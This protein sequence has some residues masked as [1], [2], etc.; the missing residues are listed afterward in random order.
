MATVVR[1]L[2]GQASGAPSE[3]EAQSNDRMRS[4]MGPFPERNLGCVVRVDGDCAMRFVLVGTESP[5]RRHRPE[6]FIRTLKFAA[7]VALL[8]AVS[9]RGL[10]SL[11]LA[12]LSYR[13]ARTL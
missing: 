4:A 13:R 12:L 9:A 5:A 8:T 1:R 7:T 2:T 10:G 6:P 3:V 11:H